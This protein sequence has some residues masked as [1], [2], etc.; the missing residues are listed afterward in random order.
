M[1]NKL[2]VTPIPA[3]LEGR[4]TEGGP[5]SGSYLTIVFNPTD[6]GNTEAN[7]LYEIAAPCDMRLMEATCWSQV[8]TS[9]PQW[10]VLHNAVAVVAQNNMAASATADTVAAADL[11]A[12][13][14][15]VSKGQGIRIRLDSD[16]GDDATNISIALTYY[17][18]GH[19]VADA[20]DD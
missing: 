19:V 2:A 17:V 14:R 12:A 15:N 11:V 3:H 4:S 6:L 10:Q 5:T 20:D 1:S 18:R 9:D 7:V 8:V 13:A 16:G